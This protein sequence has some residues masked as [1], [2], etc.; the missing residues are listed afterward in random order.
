MDVPFKHVGFVV[1]SVWS[2]TRRNTTCHRSPV[3]AKWTAFALGPL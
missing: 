2:R 1:R 3:M